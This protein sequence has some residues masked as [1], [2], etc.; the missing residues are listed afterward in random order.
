MILIK[1][2]NVTKKYKNRLII[3]NSSFEIDSKT[4]YILIGE[5]G[6]GKTTIIK[7]IIGLVNLTSGSIQKNSDNIGYLPDKCLLPNHIT[8]KSFL[9][10]FHKKN[11]LI[12][13]YLKEWGL[14]EHKDKKVNNLSK[15]M[16]QKLMIIN[17]LLKEEELYI[18]D[19]PLNGL[20]E[21]SQKKFFSKI[22][23]LKKQKKSIIVATHFP[24]LYKKYFDRVLK[25]EN[26]EIIIYS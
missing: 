20:D 19:E 5:N 17:M 7:I 23:S 6:T 2:L 16:F 13:T 21:I 25:I 12:E 10:L 18:L 26:G 11:K 3:K 4:S 9:E 8:I 14:Y 22:I 24:K 1:L 15:G